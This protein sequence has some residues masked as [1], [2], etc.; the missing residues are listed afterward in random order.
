MQGMQM[1]PKHFI[2]VGLRL[3]ALWL[4]IGSFQ[5]F[6]IASAIERFNQQ[7]GNSPIWMVTLV[8]A[9]YLVLAFLLWIM[10]APIATWLLAGVPRP[11]APSLTLGDIIVAGCVLMGLWWLKE[12]IIPLTSLWLRAIA[13]SGDQSPINL[14][15]PTG[16]V[17]T[18]LHLLEIICG[19]LLVFRP[20]DIA[21]WVVGKM[22]SFA[23][24]DMR[25]PTADDLER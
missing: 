8:I 20:F 18:A 4:V 5:V 2:A 11:Q 13:L 25:K 6:A 22:P 16:K 24:G 3:F 1:T 19:L 17:S 23:S 7:L 21:K 12:A 14:L 10:S 9:V 15:G